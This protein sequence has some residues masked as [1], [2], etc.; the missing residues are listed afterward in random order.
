MHK[1]KAVSLVLAASSLAIGCS[2]GISLKGATPSPRVSTAQDLGP[3]SPDTVLDLVL[4]IHLRDSTLVHKF[5]D[6]QVTTRDVMSPT[7]FGDAFGISAGEYFRIV[8]WLRAQGFTVTQTAAGRSTISVSATAEVIERAFGTSVHAFVD[9]DGRFVA[10]LDELSLAPEIAPSVSGVVG[11]DGG[12]PWVSHAIH[13]QASPNA[14]LASFGAVQLETQYS[15]TAISMPGKGQT[16]AILGAGGAPP[17]SDVTSYITA[18]KPYGLTTLPGT[19]TQELVGG[20]DRTGDT[21]SGEQIENVLD[22]EM[23]LSMAPL[24]TV[25]HVIAATNSPGL[26]TDGILHRQHRA[27]GARRHRQLRR[28]RARRGA[29]DVGA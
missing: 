16:I 2:N 23:V 19:Y 8:T 13:V 12:L 4:G 26:F 28:L 27:A 3:A 15:T 7:D 10:A 6:A 9:S 22:A 20:P 21:A 25:V 17:M 5:L 24:A 11:L 29:G 14:A 18:N 1:L